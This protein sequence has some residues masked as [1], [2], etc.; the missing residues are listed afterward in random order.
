MPHI[1]RVQHPNK[2]A[3]KRL[4]VLDRRR[5]N[6]QESTGKDFSWGVVDG[7]WSW[8]VSTKKNGATPLLNPIEIT[9]E[10]QRVYPYQI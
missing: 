10:I 9:F 4:V 7:E 6:C 2:A 1:Y 8:G 3:E 5:I